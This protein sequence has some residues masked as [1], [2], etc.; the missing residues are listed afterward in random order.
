MISIP[1]ITWVKHIVPIHLSQRKKIEMIDV[2]LCGFRED[3]H[4]SFL[5]LR[6]IAGKD[7]LEPLTIQIL[8]QAVH[9]MQLMFTEQSIMFGQTACAN[10][11]RDNLIYLEQLSK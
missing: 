9:K 2:C 8:K 10:Y 5:M 7:G 6:T 11:K 4:A 3:Q 1:S